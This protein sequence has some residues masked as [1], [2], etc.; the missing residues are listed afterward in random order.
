MLKGMARSLLQSHQNRN[1]YFVMI[2]EHPDSINDGRFLNN[3]TGARWSDIP[4][5]FH[6]GAV[7]LSFAD[8]HSGIHQW[9][10]LTT[11]LPV[12]FFYAT[13]TLDAAGL[14]DYRWLMNRTAVPF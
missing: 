14:D 8:G 9:T 1:S 3:P 5:S 6:H 12:R 2:D 4:G 13:P 11:K 7:S 10:S